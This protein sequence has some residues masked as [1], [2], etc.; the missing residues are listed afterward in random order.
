MVLAIGEK[1]PQFAA[2][3]VADAAATDA[4]ETSEDSVASADLCSL[5]AEPR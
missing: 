4:I 3:V 1:S 5:R 2:S